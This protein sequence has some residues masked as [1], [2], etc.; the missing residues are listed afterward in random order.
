[1]NKILIMLTMFISVQTFAHENPDRMGQCFVVDGNNLTK[2][3]II[4]SGGGT[5]GLY[6]ALRIGKQNFLIEE[7]TMDSDSDERPVFMGKDDDHMVDAVNYYRDGTTKKL[8]KNY[9]D[10]SWSCYSQIK[11]KLDACYRIR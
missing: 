6:T 1:M 2:P 9:K 8:I 11:G 5:G 4:S 7:S 10:D 3:C